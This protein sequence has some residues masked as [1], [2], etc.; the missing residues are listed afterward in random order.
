MKRLL[1]F[2]PFLLL[3]GIFSSYG[4]ST[5][6]DGFPGDSTTVN[7]N[8]GTVPGYVADTSTP[9]LW[10]IGRTH[11][12]FFTSDSAGIVAIM[13]DTLNMYPVNANKSFTIKVQNSMNLIIDFWHRYQTTSGHDGGIVEFSKD[14]GVTWENVKGECNT[15]SPYFGLGVVTTN[16][17]AAADTLVAAGQ[18]GF[19]GIQSAERYSRFQ[20]ESPIP[21]RT[22]SGAGCTV[23]TSDSVFIRFRFVSDSI[24]DSLA[25]WIIDSIQVERDLWEGIVEVVKQEALRIAPNPSLD[26]HFTFPAL[27]DADEYTLSIYNAIGQRVL[28]LPYKQ[29]LDLSHYANGLYFYSAT[30]GSVTYRGRLL[31]E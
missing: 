22:T 18:P 15:D 14:H 21:I 11:K 28:S 7:F 13:T 12:S 29:S 3:C 23:W 26:G 2:I 17:Y 31:H 4:Q 10:Q 6:H 19:S 5:V 24:S 27:V 9:P 20:F 8:G 16:F 1:C 25:G 30:N